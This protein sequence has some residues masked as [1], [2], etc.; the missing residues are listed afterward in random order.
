MINQYFDRNLYEGALEEMKFWVRIVFEHLKF[1]RNGVDP[2]N[3]RAFRMIDEYEVATESF[4]DRFIFPV[5][6]TADSQTLLSLIYNTLRVTVPVRDFKMYLANEINNCRLLSLIDPSL[7]DH[8]RRE[9]DYF[10]GQLN[11][12]I[13]EQTPERERIGIPGQGRALTAP[14]KVI[15]NLTKEE[16]FKYAIENI[17]FFSRIHGE[18]AHHITLITRPEIQENIRQQ[19]SQ[20]EQLLFANIEKARQ[21]EAT[22]VGFEDLMTSTYSLALEFGEF[23]KQ[24]ND[25]L[26]RCS[27]PTGRVNAWPLL[28]DH[29]VREGLYF[30]DILSRLINGEAVP[31]PD[32]PIYPYIK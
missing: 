12:V 8:L 26:H 31:P 4:Y 7:A 23:G 24:I 19:A 13:G 25:S 17:M 6:K 32:T 5:P 27:V 28:A 22:R 18:H 16:F 11:Y 21:V 2:G 15:P 20:F 10:I 14:R 29:I 30:I 9:T 3:E 1:H